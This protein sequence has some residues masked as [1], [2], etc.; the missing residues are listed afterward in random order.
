[1]QS[2]T[3]KRIKKRNGEIVEFH[4]GKILIAISKAFAAIKGSADQE[5]TQTITK[6][7]LKNL[8]E[9]FVDAAPSVE[10]VQNAVE[11]VLMENN[12]FD[13]AKAY[14]IYRY[15]HTKIREKKKEEVQKKIEGEEL[16]VVKRNGEREIFSME[17]LQKTLSYI[18]KGHEEIVDGSVVANQVRAELY[19]NIPTKEI[20]RTIIMVLRSLIEQDP[21]FSFAATRALLMRQYKHVIGHS[22]IRF[23]ELDDDLN[24]MFIKNIEYGVQVGKLDPRMLTFDLQE[25]SRSL[26]HDRDNQH[27]YLSAQTLVDRYFMEDPVSGKK[28]ETPQLFWMRVA[29]GLSLNEEYK[30]E[31]A[32]EF[33]EVMSTLMYVPSTPTLF[34][35]GT[36]HPQMSSCYITTVEDSLDHIFKSYSDNAQLSKWSGGIGNDWTNLRGMGTLIRGTGVESQ[37]VIPFLKIANDVTA[38]INRSG[39]RRGA[40]CAYLESWHW[41]IEDFLELRKNTGD[42]R[43]RTHDMNTANWI[44]DLFMKRVKSD[45]EWTLFSPDEVSDLHHVYGKEFERKYEEYERKAEAGQISKYRKV[46]AKDLWKKMLTMLFETGHPWIT[47]KDPSNIRSPQ[48]HVGVVHCSNLC[49]EITLNTSEYETAVC[50]LGSVN[51]EKHVVGGELNQEM[52]RKTVVTAMRILDNV[53]DLNFYPTQEARNANM[54]HRPVGLGVMGFQNALYK[55]GIDFDSDECVEFADK[56]GEMIAYYAILGSAEL[57]RDRGPYQSFRGSKWDRGIFPIDTV[58]LLEKER[59]MKTTVSKDSQ[60]DWSPVREAVREYGMRNSNCM[61]VAPTATIS[62]IAGSTP[63]VE[64]IY[65]NIYVKANQAGDFTIVNPYL[66][67]DLKKFDL[68]DTEMLGKLK[69]HDGKIAEITEIPAELKK[70]YKEVFEID[71]KWLIRAAAHRGKWIDQSQSINIFYS[72]KSGKDIHTIYMSAWEAGLKT[73]YYLRTLAISQVE[74]STVSTE[75]FGSTH[76]RETKNVGVVQAPSSEQ[77]SEVLIPT[78]TSSSVMAT[79]PASSTLVNEEKKEESELC[80]IEDPDCEACQ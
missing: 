52:I 62:N 1:M 15:E 27:T 79:V 20:E 56:A 65:K 55:L 23:S 54:K 45:E 29:M 30:N 16:F 11:F 64:P 68:W 34:H 6:D 33:Y 19:E 60:M 48:D 12:H 35:A 67:E 26:K 72:G 61:A 78:K 70:K 32:K 14:I 46:K 41:D 42:E 31:R 59:D 39:R 63:G 49:T 10:D 71:P 37:G 18:A 22:D 80:R 76:L 50:N 66:V 3:I 7:V 43:R 53:I 24:Q 38:A 9:E 36:S 74:K 25:L 21:A 58:V 77:Q 73:T 44:P 75:Q 69:Y 57:A 5:L 17:K 47:W 28:F 8:E 13:I 4:P 2:S 40:V 51:L